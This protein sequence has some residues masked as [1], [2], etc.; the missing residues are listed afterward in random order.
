MQDDLKERLRKFR[1]FL[2]GEADL[3]CTWFGEVPVIGQSRGL[4]WWR[5]SHLP[6]LDEA[7][8]RIAALEAKLAEKDALL[9]ECGEAMNLCSYAMLEEWLPEHLAEAFVATLAKI[10]DATD[11]D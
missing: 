9:R 6:V 5:K 7:A 10:K 11:A 8:D 4:F 1:L 3:G 2:S